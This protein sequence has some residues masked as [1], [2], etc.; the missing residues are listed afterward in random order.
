M[1]RPLSDKSS[2]VLNYLA[3]VTGEETQI[4]VLFIYFV[5]FHGEKI[6]KINLFT[7]DR[8]A[9]STSTLCVDCNSTCYR[10]TRY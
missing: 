8:I 6:Y 10:T 5:Y 4:L 2:D 3:G 1:C 7:F 9:L